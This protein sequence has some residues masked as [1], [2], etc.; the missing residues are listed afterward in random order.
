MFFHFNQN[1]SGGYFIEGDEVW[2]DVIIEAKDAKHA[3]EIAEQIGIYFHGSC[4]GRD[5]SC[6]GDRWHEVMGMDGSVKPSIY[7]EELKEV[8]EGLFRDKCYIYY[9]N[10]E[11]EEYIF[12]QK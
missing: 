3:N 6:C 7:G 5:C 10:G 8:K 9:L 2:R 4:K 11:K 12:E 1:N